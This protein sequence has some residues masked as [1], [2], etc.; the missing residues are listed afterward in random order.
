M[1][2]DAFFDLAASKFAEG[3]VSIS[4][5][6]VAVF[7]GQKNNS[8][9]GVSHGDNFQGSSQ[10]T[11]RRFERF[12]LEVLPPTFAGSGIIDQDSETKVTPFINIA[13]FGRRQLTKGPPKY[14]TRGAQIQFDNDKEATVYA[15]ADGSLQDVS[16]PDSSQ[17]I[18]ELGKD[19]TVTLGPVVSMK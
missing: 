15:F 13:V 4:A 14:D 12:D 18:L 10:Y 8:M 7:N 3:Y 2:F 5:V 1:T 16:N 17:I 9:P 6:V 11:P 19:W